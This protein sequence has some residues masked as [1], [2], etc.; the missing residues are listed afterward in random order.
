[1]TTVC[2][3]LWIVV[4]MSILVVI[5]ILVMSMWTVKKWIRQ[6]KIEFIYPKDINVDA[7]DI[8]WQ[9]TDSSSLQDGLTD[10]ECHHGEDV[11][12]N[13]THVLAVENQQYVSDST[14]SADDGYMVPIN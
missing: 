7:S 6:C 14:P 1:M 5:L 2:L 3:D 10:I 9:D 13:N 8:S 12:Q 4:M 11:E